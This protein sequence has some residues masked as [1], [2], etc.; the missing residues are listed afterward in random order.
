M[1]PYTSHTISNISD[2]RDYTYD[3]FGIVSHIGANIHK[4]HYKNFAKSNG[5]WFSFDDHVVE[6]V[7][8]ELVLR[9]KAYVSA[10]LIA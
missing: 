4:G 5:E 3:L 1:K 10:I 6:W 7:T 2:T 8:E 9:S